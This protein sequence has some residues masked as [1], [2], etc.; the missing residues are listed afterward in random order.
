MMLRM[1]LLSILALAG[2]LAA[3]SDGDGPS[4][5]SGLPSPTAI[6]DPA[7][8][9][10]AIPNL[11]PLPTPYLFEGRTVDCP[12]VHPT[13]EDAIAACLPIL[14]KNLYADYVGACDA[15]TYT[16]SCS[17]WED[18]IASPRAY[19]VD[20]GGADTFERLILERQADGWIV[21]LRAGCATQSLVYLEA[22]MIMR[23]IDL[24]PVR[25][26][27]CRFAPPPLPRPTLRVGPGEESIV[28]NARTRLTVSSGGF[29][30]NRGVRL[31]IRVTNISGATLA[32]P[33][34]KVSDIKLVAEDGT[35]FPASEVGGTLVI[36]IPDGFPNDASWVGWLVFPIEE[37]GMYTLQYP[38]QPNISLE[39][40]PEHYDVS[41]KL[42]H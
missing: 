31:P 4:N 22:D 24:S 18:G 15:S 20:V 7:L 42:R 3:C 36:P 26:D 40:T 11:P 14:Y 39:L 23:A 28:A 41:R 13:P 33:Q 34:A 21:T 25:T 8:T 27:D 38:D 19:Y 1:V 30:P 12:D 10:T 2:A 16:I 9:P 17:I 6:I 37:F 29:Y 32:W 35:S 5:L